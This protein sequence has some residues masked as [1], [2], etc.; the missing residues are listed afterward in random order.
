MFVARRSMTYGHGAGEPVDRGQVIALQGLVNDEKLVRLGYVSRADRGVSVVGCG[1]CGAKF[2]T[3]EALSA[4]GRD[5]HPTERLSPEAQEL[6]DLERTEA[7]HKRED[8][9][10]PLDL[11][12]T[13]ASRAAGVAS[14]EV[15]TTKAASRGARTST[16]KR[17]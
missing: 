1:I 3:D 13:R 17:R 8:E 2:T 16:K 15:N 10:A 14:S 12:K 11:T 5:R 6:R 4:H 7:R 9:L